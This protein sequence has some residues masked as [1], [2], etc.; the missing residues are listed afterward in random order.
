MECMM[1]IYHLILIGTTD[2]DQVFWASEPAYCLESFSKCD[3]TRMD[4][5]KKQ[6]WL[7]VKEQLKDVNEFDN[8][9][10]EIYSLKIF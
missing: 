6:R 4:V 9:V 5:V 10:V 3:T 1:M 8:P 7:E 2:S